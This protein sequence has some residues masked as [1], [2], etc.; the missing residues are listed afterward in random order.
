[1]MF[2][3]P[4]DQ[5]FCYVNQDISTCNGSTITAPNGAKNNQYCHVVKGAMLGENMMIGEHGYIANGAII[6]KN[7]RIQ[8]HVSIWNGV[9]LGENVFVGPMVIFTNHR[10]PSKRLSRKEYF[11][12]DET[13]ISDNVTIS[14]GA[15]IVA[16]CRIAEGVLIAAGSVV[17]RDLGA[18]EK[19]Y[20]LIKKVRA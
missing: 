19:A 3:E 4:D 14:A 15:I 1:M 10:D 8:N 5:G 9:I 16:P 18:Q 6:G 13:F 20:G 2:N 12:P 11:K 7:T 17:L